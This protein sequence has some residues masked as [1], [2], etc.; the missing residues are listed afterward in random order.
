MQ[1]IIHGT[2]YSK[3]DRSLMISRYGTLIWLFGV[4]LTG[5]SPFE[6]GIKTKP[7]SLHR[8]NPMKLMATHFGKV[9]RLESKP[10]III[11]TKVSAKVTPPIRPLSEGKLSPK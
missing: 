7:T 9:E 10:A 2:R 6:R 5:F 11:A 8:E 4:W 3:K 1:K